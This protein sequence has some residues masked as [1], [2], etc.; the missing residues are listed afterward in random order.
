MPKLVNWY[1]SWESERKDR[2][3]IDPAKLCHFGVRCLDDAMPFIRN[4]EL[5]VIGAESGAGKSELGLNIAVKNAMSGK[6]VALFYLEGGD[7]EAIAR[8]KHSMV[9]E[10]LKKEECEIRYTDFITWKCNGV[11]GL[12]EIENKI[13]QQAKKEIGDNLL[14]YELDGGVNIKSLLDSLYELVNGDWFKSD[15]GVNI[16][17]DII[18]ID[19]LQYF[20]L[21]GNDNEIKQTTEIL[22]KI[23]ELTIDVKV[24]VILIS[25]FRKTD[26]TQGLP[27]QASFYGSSNIPKISTTSIVISSD[28][29]KY[30]FSDGLYPTW[31]RFVKS[32]IGLRDN[33]VIKVD[34]DINQN[35]YSDQ[36]QLHNVGAKGFPVTEMIQKQYLP[37]WA[38]ENVINIRKVYEVESQFINW[39]D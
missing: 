3:S 6:K 39:N 8:I 15:G 32:G 22:R 21:L 27:D 33:Y 19:H 7:K 34:F 24:P 23:K 10:Y 14:L 38:K 31:F 30:D 17:L 29:T 1:E 28:K 18:I 37:R 12:E 26:K 5:V 2:T 36:Y 16:P 9:N 35:K 25:H 11:K 4:N 20:E 13:F